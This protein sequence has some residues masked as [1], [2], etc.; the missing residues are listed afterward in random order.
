MR[1]DIFRGE[2]K[3]RITVDGWL[4]LL[5]HIHGASQVQQ[6]QPKAQLLSKGLL[7]LISNELELDLT[8][9]HTQP[10]I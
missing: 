7:F 10:T 5:C 4:F 1:A 9:F 6:G 3:I 2:V 8:Y